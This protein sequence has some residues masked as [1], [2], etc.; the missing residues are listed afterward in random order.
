MAT[1]IIKPRARIFHGHCWV[2]G[3]EIRSI[4]GDPKPG[5]TVGLKDQKNRFLGS[6]I[7]NPKSQIVF[8]RYSFR[9]QDLSPEFFDSRIQ[10]AIAYR[11]RLPL[12]QDYIRMV[13]SESDGLPGL[14]IDRY[15]DALVLQT[16]TLA[17]DQRLDII[18][19]TLK[20]LFPGLCVIARNDSPIRKAEG[21]ELKNEILF[22]EPASPYQ[23]KVHGVRC[24]IDLQDGQ[25]T[26]LYLDQLANYE[27]VGIHA[28][29]RTVLDA[30]CHQGGFAQACALGGAAAVT[31]IDSSSSAI[32]HARGI[33]DDAGLNIKY[34]EANCFDFLRHAADKGRTFDLIILD[35]PSFTRNKKGLPGALRGYKELH[36]RALKMLNPGGL[37]ATFSCS[38]HVDAAI[39]R[40]MIN[41]ASVDARRTLRLCETFTQ[42][43][44]HPVLTAIPETE[45]LRGMLLETMG[46]W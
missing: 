4:H 8:R 42:R 13:W 14:V 26:G 44:D 18:R 36:L 22:G 17:M 34:D 25:K 12:A 38:H 16:L 19:D 46:A 20:N 40:E 9:K 24:M 23:V 33:S 15:G 21:L 37:L 30:F 1:A 41:T 28:K 7:Y 5:E 45:Y 3:S 29:G 31:G 32:A 27:K 2:Y 39:F 11:Q 10:R 6:A 43:P 35:P